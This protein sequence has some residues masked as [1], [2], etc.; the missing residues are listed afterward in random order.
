[1]KWKCLKFQSVHQ[2]NSQQVY[3]IGQ[4]KVATVAT[5]KA[6]KVATVATFMAQKVATL[7]NAHGGIANAQGIAHAQGKAFCV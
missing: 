1:M 6:Q 4:S 2:E 3:L 7:K 5:F